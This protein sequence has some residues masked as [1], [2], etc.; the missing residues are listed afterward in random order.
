MGLLTTLREWFRG[1]LGGT[2]DGDDEDGGTAGSEP[3]EAAEPD[4]DRLDPNAATE[5][6]STANDDAVDKLR[7]VRQTAPGAESDDG[8]EPTESGADDGTEPV[9]S[10]ADDGKR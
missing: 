5:T 2:G 9:G 7:E 8:T 10:D 6:R 1:L 3:A 4:E